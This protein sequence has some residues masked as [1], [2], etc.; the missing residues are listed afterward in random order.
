[1][2]EKGRL[3]VDIEIERQLSQVFFGGG[4]DISFSDLSDYYNL[5]K[6]IRNVGGD[7]KNVFVKMYLQKCIFQN[8]FFRLVRL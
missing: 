7:T 1:M 8:E 4:L 2:K 5:G 6:R 3:R